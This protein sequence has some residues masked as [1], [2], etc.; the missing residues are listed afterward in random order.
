MRW[1]DVLADY[2]GLERQPAPDEPG[3]DELILEL[4]FAIADGGANTPEEMGAVVR[5]VM[6][7]RGFWPLGTRLAVKGQ[8]CDFVFPTPPAPVAPARRAP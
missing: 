6:V 7:S 1:R 2:P 8:G 4:E 5:R 3:F